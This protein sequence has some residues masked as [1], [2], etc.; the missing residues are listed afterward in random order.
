MA[1]ETELT[2]LAQALPS[3]AAAAAGAAGSDLDVLKEHPVEELIALFKKIKAVVEGMSL[4][5]EQYPAK[6]LPLPIYSECDK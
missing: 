3:A 6:T 4:K 2:E 5:L 1:R